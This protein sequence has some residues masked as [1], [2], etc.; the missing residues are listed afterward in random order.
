MNAFVVE[1]MEEWIDGQTK[2]MNRFQRLFW[3]L[4]KESQIRFSPFPYRT[5]LMCGRGNHTSNRVKIK[6]EEV[7]RE[8]SKSGKDEKG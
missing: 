4:G 6:W 2:E 8:N 1:Y 5:S 7:I 3:S